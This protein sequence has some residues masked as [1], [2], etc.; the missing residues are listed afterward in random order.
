[1]VDLGNI[2]NVRGVN[3]KPHDACYGGNGVNR[4]RPD[5][6]AASGRVVGGVAVYRY[7]RMADCQNRKVIEAV[8]VALREV[9]GGQVHLF[10]VHVAAKMVLDGKI[11]HGVCP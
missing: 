11:K 4:M 5:Q 6:N 1:V 10:G 7:L 3:A 8:F 9:P 2:G